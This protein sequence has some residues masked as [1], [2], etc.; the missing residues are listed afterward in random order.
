MILA[1]A[2]LLALQDPQYETLTLETGTRTDR[3]E[4]RDLNGDGK[5]DLILQNGRDLQIFLQK[6]GG[7]ASK[8][9]PVVRMDATVFLWTFGMLDGQAHPAV[10]TAGSRGIQAIPFDGT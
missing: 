1:L 7:Y 6:N 2:A 8:P 9:Q 5:P 4:T 10:I 3:I